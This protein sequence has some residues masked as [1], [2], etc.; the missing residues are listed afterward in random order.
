MAPTTRAA[1]PVSTVVPTACAPRAAI[2]SSATIFAALLPADIKSR[3]L[4]DAAKKKYTT[5]SGKEYALFHRKQ[6]CKYCDQYTNYIDADVL[7]FN[8]RKYLI[9]TA[10][11]RIIQ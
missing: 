8:S 2:S 10:I 3:T 1:A 4:E 5:I 11:G 9:E 7:I 6:G